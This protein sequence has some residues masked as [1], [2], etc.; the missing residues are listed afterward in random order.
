MRD[1]GEIAVFLDLGVAEEGWSPHTRAAYRRDLELYSAFLGDLGKSGVQ[2]STAPTILAFLSRRRLEG[3]GDSTLNRRLAAIRSFHRHLLAEGVLKEDVL[4][5]LPPG[6]RTRR[7]PKSL[8][9]EQIEALLEAPRGAA[10]LARRD[11]AL[12]EILYATGIRV[13]EA[14]GLDLGDLHPPRDGAD[15]PHLKVK[16]KG[17]KERFIPLHGKAAAALA[18]WL[19]EGRPR[20][21]RAG[22]PPAIFLSRGGRRLRRDGV[23][24]RVREW[25]RKA[26]VPVPV[27]PH[28]LRHS[29]ATHLVHEGAGLREVQEMLGHANLETTTLY[30]SVDGERLKALHARCHP[31]G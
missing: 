12:L 27:T 22:S 21:V 6:R 30:T 7:L 25:G 29:F 20:L 16:G 28:L 3:D 18:A 26:G 5:L 17:G 8:T 2:E 23:Y 4:S 19:R 10:P 24:R 9:R 31:R 15:L 1:H 13:S 11:R 14:C